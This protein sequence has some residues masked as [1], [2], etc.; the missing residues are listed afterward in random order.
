MLPLILVT[1]VEIGLLVAGLMTAA[2]YLV[3]VE[4]RIAAWVQD[5]IGPNRVG[6]PLTKVRLFGLGQPLADGVKIFLKD[7]YTPGG[8]DKAMYFLAP[9]VLF[10]TAI[11]VYA[12]IPFGSLLPPEALPMS[13]GVTQPVRL[14]PPRGSTWA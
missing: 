8:V 11:A 3:L 6:I 13:W 7:Q 14:W 1:L 5:R 10:A 12:V 9:V 4:R 2:A